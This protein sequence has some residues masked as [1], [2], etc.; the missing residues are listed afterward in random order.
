MAYT[1]D[2]SDGNKT[3]ISV[4]SKTVDTTTN[5]SLVG[6]GYEGFGEVMAENLL[7]IMENFASSNAPSRPVEGQFWYDSTNNQIKYFDDTVANGG[8]WKA[9]ASMTYHPVAPVGTGE[10]NGHF[11]LD[12]DTGVVYIRYNGAWNSIADVAGDTGVNARTRYDTSDTAHRTIE[13]VVGGIVV[14]IASSDGTDWAPQTSGANIEYLEDG[15][16]LLNTDFPIIRAGM[17]MNTRTG[18]FFSGTATQ[19]QYA[20]L[21]ERYHADGVYDYGTV[22]KI[23]GQ[24]E[25]TQTTHSYCPCVFGIVSTAPAFMMNSMA[26]PDETHPYIALSGRVPVKVT[27]TIQ[28][29]ERL[30]TSDIPGHA[31]GAGPT[32]DWRYVIGRALED[33][34][35]D[36]QGIIEGV[37]GTK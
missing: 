28:K 36:G 32:P 12:S 11:W 3:A 13:V 34:R 24:H 25:V 17:N 8:N 37:V 6:Q 10:Q 4:A 2:Y 22:V 27:G 14:S 33:K 21:A 7:H 23:G 29:G 35:C 30:V 26:G 18:Y 20:D 9:V 19:A 16:T 15:T 31:M 1:I 5:I